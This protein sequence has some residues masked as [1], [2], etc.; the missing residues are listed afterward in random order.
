MVFQVWQDRNI[1]KEELTNWL[2]SKFTSFVLSVQDSHEIND[3]SEW[4]KI[5][6]N[7]WLCA[8]AYFSTDTEILRSNLLEML[9]F[10][11]GNENCPH[12]KTIKNNVSFSPNITTSQSFGDNIK[13]K[14]V[15]FDNNTQI[16]FINNEFVF[17][18]IFYEKQINELLRGFITDLQNMTKQKRI[19]LIIKFLHLGF[20]E[21]DS[22]FVDWFQNHF[23]YYTSRIRSLKILII[24]QGDIDSL[25]VIDQKYKNKITTLNL[26]E[27]STA[28]DG[29][30]LGNRE[31]C[32]GAID[33]ETEEINYG[34]FQKKLYA[35]LKR[36][37][38]K[39]E[40]V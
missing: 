15:T 26:T 32:E 10:E 8:Q 40:N 29:L 21:I 30:F 33:A 7:N 13:A 20:S 22:T 12:Y 38:K 2:D 23:Y 18:S 37:S 27:I 25:S 28:T 36:I 9:V 24:V 31:F 6:N 4:V 14:N 5:Q 17:K 16:N 3:I 34:E 1:I 39:I 35:Q 19:L 11:L